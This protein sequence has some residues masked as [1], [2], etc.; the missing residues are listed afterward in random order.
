MEKLNCRSAIRVNL[1]QDEFKNILV[2]PGSLE[3]LGK[4]S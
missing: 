2:L 3:L 1:S 4:N